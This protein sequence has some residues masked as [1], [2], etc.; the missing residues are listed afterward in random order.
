[1]D[2]TKLIAELNIAGGFASDA[3]AIT[4]LRATLET[5]GELLPLAK[6][7]EIAAHLPLETRPS[8]IENPTRAC[9]EFALN[10]F[11]ARVALRSHARA[12]TG[13]THV[14]SVFVVLLGLPCGPMIWATMGPEYR[15]FFDELRAGGRF[16]RDSV[17]LTVPKFSEVA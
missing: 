17:P 1:M 6:A 11:C 3:E 12:H 16:K 5:L 8:L 4:A 14:R 15:G 9:R 13:R 10:E 7:A 2:L